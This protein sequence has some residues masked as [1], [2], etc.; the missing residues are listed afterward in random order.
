[1]GN[2]FVSLT[3]G[4]ECGLTSAS[5]WNAQPLA[6][7]DTDDALLSDSANAAAKNKAPQAG[8]MQLYVGGHGGLGG[9]GNVM[10]SIDPELTRPKDPARLTTHFGVRATGLLNLGNTCF[11]NCA[12][13]CIGHSPLFREYMLSQRFFEDINKSNPLG[14]KGKI[15]MAYGKLME[16]LWGQMGEDMSCFA[17]TTFRDEFLRHRPM[18]QESNQHDSHEF[19]VSLLD[20][21]HEDLNRREDDAQRHSYRL[22]RRAR[23]SQLCLTEASFTTATSGAIDGLDDDDEGWGS[24]DS[25]CSSTLP[26]SS[27]AT[28]GSM[29]WHAHASRN[30]SVI[31]DLFHGQMR[32]ETVCASCEARKVTFDPFVYFSVPIPEP[33]WIRLEVKIVFLIRSPTNVPE[34]GC[35]S[36]NDKNDATWWSSITPVICRG[37]WLPRQST[38]SALFDAIA[39]AY[40]LPPVRNRF[41]LAQVRRCRIARLFDEVDRVQ[42]LGSNLELFAFERA[43]SIQEASVAPSFLSCQSRDEPDASPIK[44]HIRRFEDLAIGARADATTVDGVWYPA[45]V[46][47]DSNAGED[48]SS[49]RVM[50]HFDGLDVTWD[51]W[52]SH[53][54]W[55]D[56]KLAP[57]HTQTKKEDKLVEVQVVM[58]LVTTQRRAIPM[59][60]ES[61]QPTVGA[62]N[63][64]NNQE[65]A[66]QN[67]VSLE[68][69][70]SP[71]LLTLSSTSTTRELHAAILMQA[72]RFMTHA[73]HP[74]IMD[75]SLLPFDARLLTVDT[76]GSSLGE[77]LPDDDTGI[78]Q[79]LNPKS[80]IVLDWRKY[81]DYSYFEQPSRDYVPKVYAKQLQLDPSDDAST[82]TMRPTSANDAVML[83]NS[84]SLPKCLDELFKREII[85]HEDMW[86]CE[87]CGEQRTGTRQADVW[88][89][90]DLVMIQLKRFQYH[91]S[92]YR[93][94][95]RTMVDC[96]LKGLDFSPWVGAAPNSNPESCVYDLYAVVNHV[97]GLA[98]GHYTAYCRYDSDFEEASRMFTSLD[99]DRERSA[100]EMPFTDMW[101]RFDDEK[102]V[103]IAPGD[104]ISDAAYVLF[105]KRR[106]LSTRNVL[107][108]SF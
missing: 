4:I 15:A 18:F 35:D 3:S 7:I 44:S 14:T 42:T 54:D 23:S 62:R 73:F 8:S 32:S 49:R 102:V 104:V 41:V 91:E 76:I 52:F 64:T 84:T 107:A 24:L 55:Q 46:V 11:I 2:D 92:G 85:E 66:P 28:L 48:P 39:E 77:K 87:R 40:H 33:K 78:M 59:R 1:M 38:V 61:Q 81:T 34:V 6:G 20:A 93:E 80:V 27:D 105:Y 58:R 82:D 10:V 36:D 75:E 63:V 72:T 53:E 45:T 31:V 19:I 9:H 65:E 90:P 94:K 79:H 5:R 70:G 29:S 30:A 83:D 37:F 89:L 74:G 43:T 108:Y 12:L 103:E 26:L 51:T 95:I 98:R 17:P 71:M 16:L 101:L 25:S 13:Q 68:I 21:L 69:F 100:A 60:D 47:N 99:R 97:G 56:G 106:K 50:V 67:F 22:S 86:M 96:P 57:L 88:K